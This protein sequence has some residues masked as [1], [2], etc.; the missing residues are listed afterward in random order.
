MR[1]GKLFLRL[2]NEK[3]AFMPERLRAVIDSE[4]KMTGY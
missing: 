3:V 4:S 1:G 2:S